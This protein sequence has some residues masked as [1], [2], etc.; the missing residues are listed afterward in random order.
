MRRLVTSRWIRSLLIVVSTCVV[1]IAIVLFVTVHAFTAKP[2]EWSI[3]MRF[4]ILGIGPTIDASVATLIRVGT[5]PLGIAA[6]DGR[7]IA[8]REGT[9][10]F[11][12]SDE[13]LAIDCAPCLWQMPGLG[14]DRIEVTSARITMVGKADHLTGSIAAG[15]IAGHYNARFDATSMKLDVA[16]DRAPIAA[17][18]RLFGERV[19]ETRVAQIAGAASFA[20]RLSLPDGSFSVKP[21]I[22]GF[23]V[24]GLGTELLAG[25]MPE[26]ACGNE[27]IRGAVRARLSRDAKGFGTWLPRTVV[28]AEDQRFDTHPG[29]DLVELAASLSRNASAATIER[30]AS[31]I[32]QQLARILYVGS[33][34]STSRKL[35]ELLYAVEM[36]QTLGKPRMLQLY[37]AVAPWGDG[38]CGAQAAAQRYFPVDAAKLSGA[39]AVW[40]AAMLHAPDTEYARWQSRGGIDLVR[41][42]WVVHGLQKT[43]RATRERVVDD[44]QAMA[45]PPLTEMPVTNDLSIRTVVTAEAATTA[46]P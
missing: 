6:L 5:Q 16:F 43:T 13:G 42:T 14:G 46:Q 19:P 3:P 22:D 15:D 35:R 38:V 30:G 37:L 27:A 21:A 41:A 33:E 12:R 18:Y 8:T 44:L 17:Y 40:L 25:R 23:A 39:Q 28:A 32:P 4:G 36:E 11:T 24:A 34:R 31:T 45:S 29:Y 1:T 20:I 10:H 2:G 26:V 7:T 9:L